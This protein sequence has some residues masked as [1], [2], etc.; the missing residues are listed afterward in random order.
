MEQG[1]LWEL[2]LRTNSSVTLIWVELD[3]AVKADVMEKLSG[4]MVKAVHLH[5]NS[6]PSERDRDHE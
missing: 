6:P 4:L 1:T 5:P 3:P 2:D